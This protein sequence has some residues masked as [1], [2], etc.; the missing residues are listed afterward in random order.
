V[1][2]ICIPDNILSKTERLTD[3]EFDIMK[4]HT[5]MG[6][7]I[8]SRAAES[9]G[10]DEYMD[11]AKE[12]ASCHHEWW[13]GNGYPYG[14][15]GEEIPLSARIMAVADVY[16]ALTTARSYKEPFP[17]EMARDLIAG[18]ERG[19]HFEPTVVDAFLHAFK[20]IEEV[21]KKIS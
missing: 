21:R 18:K 9:M 19:T 5:V 11:L 12:M 4:M 15:S 7:E 20:D 16:D 2:K 10:T 14:L 1:G 3:E 8:V 17:P 13:N 6:A